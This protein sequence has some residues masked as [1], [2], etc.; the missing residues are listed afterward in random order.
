[1]CGNTS[2]SVVLWLKDV[3]TVQQHTTTNSTARQTEGLGSAR[4]G[5]R[6]SSRAIM[7]GAS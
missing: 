4:L 6:F 5:W 3:I 2:A 7:E 1:M